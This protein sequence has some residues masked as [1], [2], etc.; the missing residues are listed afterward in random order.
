MKKMSD[1]ADENQ[2]KIYKNFPSTHYL[3]NQKNVLNTIA[4]ITFFRRNMHRCAIDY[5][6]IKTEVMPITIRVYSENGLI[7]NISASINVIDGDNSSSVY[8]GKNIKNNK[9]YS[10]E[11]LKENKIIG[12]GRN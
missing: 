1:Y 11:I 8:L 4:W 9:F 10:F 12:G 2:L 5:F 3:S 7:F 6:G